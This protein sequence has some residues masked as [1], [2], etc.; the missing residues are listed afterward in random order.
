[1]QSSAESPWGAFCPRFV[2]ISRVG[3]ILLLGVPSPSQYQGYLA[4]EPWMC[5]MGF[6]LFLFARDFSINLREN[7]AQRGFVGDSTG[8]QLACPQGRPCWAYLG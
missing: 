5:H 2:G 7:S 3:A 6:V 4:W 1:M 8:R